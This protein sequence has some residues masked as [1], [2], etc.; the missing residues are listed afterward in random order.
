MWQSWSWQVYA[1]FMLPILKSATRGL[2]LFSDWSTEIALRAPKS[3]PMGWYLTE[4]VLKGI[5]WVHATNF[6]ISHLG[7]SLFS[8]WNTE[9]ALRER[10]SVQMGWYLTELVLKGICRVYAA[11]SEISHQGAMFYLVTG[12]QKWHLM[13]PNQ[14]EWAEIWLSWSWK[15]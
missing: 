7:L 4:L 15:V 6:E 13:R 1:E 3:V 5:R 2:S 9:I 12:T 10:K 14:S 11:N 8:D